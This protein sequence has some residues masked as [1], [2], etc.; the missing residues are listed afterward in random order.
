MGVRRAALAQGVNVHADLCPFVIVTDGSIAH[1][2][3]PG[4]R[5]LI[6]TGYAVAYR[7]G[8]AVFSDALTGIGQNFR[9]CHSKNSS[10]T[11]FTFSFYLPFLRGTIHPA[12]YV[13]SIDLFFAFVKSFCSDSNLFSHPL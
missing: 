4:P 12:Q 9:I 11:F 6:F 13:F 8:L 1:T 5:D 2:L 3:G 7:A 10:L